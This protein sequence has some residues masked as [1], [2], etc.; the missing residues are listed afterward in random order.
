[1]FCDS[2]GLLVRDLVPEEVPHGLI[3]AGWP[4]PLTAL[5]L[6]PDGAGYYVAMWRLGPAV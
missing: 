3:P 4:S 1:M 6:A 2:T 5:F